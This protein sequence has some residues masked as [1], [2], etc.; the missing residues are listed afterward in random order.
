M[1][2]RSGFY[3][4]SDADSTEPTMTTNDPQGSHSGGDH[5]ERTEAERGPSDRL[6]TAVV[7]K[8]VPLTKR[9]L[10]MFEHATR[11]EDAGAELPLNCSDPY[12]PPSELSAYLDSDYAA[13]VT[14]VAFGSAL[15]ERNIHFDSDFKLPQD[16]SDQVALLEM[17]R[18]SQPPHPD[19][20]DK[21][22][23]RLS[24]AAN[25][26][27]L[28]IHAFKMLTNGPHSLSPED[29]IES[30]DDKWYEVENH[31]T[32][33][34][35]PPQPDYYESFCLKQYPD[36]ARE[37]L[38]P[39]LA[40]SNTMSAMPTFSVEQQH[41]AGNLYNAEQKAAYT[42]AVMVR[43]AYKRHLYLGQPTEEFLNKTQALTAVFNGESLWIY[44]N[45]AT[46]ASDDPDVSDPDSLHY[47]QYLLCN[48][49]L[50]HPAGY[51]DG[52]KFIRNA[53]DWSRRRANKTR[54]LINRFVDSRLTPVTVP[55]NNDGREPL[56][57]RGRLSD[58]PTKQT[59]HRKPKQ[60]GT[61]A[62]RY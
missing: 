41:R 19:D 58:V 52:C 47:H 42:G 16:H 38:G 39:N 27:T 17:D 32:K 37:A 24:L 49:S 43:A 25:V 56:R 10:T 40:P 33:G 45:H 4:P 60:N 28:R 7:A 6:Q 22:G 3:L 18:A 59:V 9:N 29:Y 23:T 54:A 46:A 55:Q 31:L 8:R 12:H 26:E 36:D 57:K 53:Q 5:V 51:S 30:H 2:L 13:S 21:Y 11:G 48:T 14:D 35:A 50:L 34:L 20:H 15:R 44:G 61:K 1:R 62:G